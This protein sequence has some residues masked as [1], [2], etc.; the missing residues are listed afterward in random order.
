MSDE[1]T[2]PI[3]AS[4]SPASGP[5]SPPPPDEQPDPTITD[6]TSSEA[7]RGRA[8]AS[9]AAPKETATDSTADETVPVK[10]Q[11][12]LRTVGHIA[13]E[14]VIVVAVALVAS[15]LLRAF[16]VQAFFVPSGSML[17]E[18]Q[19]HD[20]ILVSRIGDIDRGEVVV[21]EDP[22]NWIPAAE[23]AAPP[24][25]LRKGLEWIG[26]LPASG[27]EHLVKRVIGMPGD[28]VVCCVDGKLSINGVVV[29]ESD[30]L[31]QG[32]KRADNYS[33]DVVVPADHIFVLGDHRYVSGDSSRRLSCADPNAGFVPMDLI[34]GRAF[35]VVWPRGNIHRLGVP[36]AYDDVPKGQDPPPTDGIV[37][38]V[39]DETCA[40]AEAP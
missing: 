10:K 24:T 2:R 14:V 12:P 19:L 4:E 32:D 3:P 16:V 20:R 26:V 17:P 11:S 25:G 28:H 31:F 38:K 8:V 5:A 6:S 7:D 37:T 9:A 21:F 30:F 18:I 33:F 34:T 22:G 23:E 1:H 13:R 27:H 39:Q 29:D 36:D 35:A 15:A 40:P